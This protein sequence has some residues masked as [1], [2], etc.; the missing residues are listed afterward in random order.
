MYKVIKYFTDLHDKD[1]PYNVGDSFPRDGVTVTEERLAELAGGD[2]K[3]GA[4][5]IE[6]AEIKEQELKE[7]AT[8]EYIADSAKK[9]SVQPREK[10]AP[11]K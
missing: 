4:P 9:S 3:Q 2:N 5:L 10:K 7:I 1:Y 11:A 8:E 6:L